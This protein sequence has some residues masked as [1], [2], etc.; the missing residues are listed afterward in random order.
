VP[1]R[2]AQPEGGCRVSCPG[3]QTRTARQN[4]LQKRV[5]GWRAVGTAILEGYR[6]KFSLE[7][8]VVVKVLDLQS[9]AVYGARAALLR[10]PLRVLRLF[11]ALGEVASRWKW[12]GGPRFDHY[13]EALRLFLLPAEGDLR[14]WVPPDLRALE[15]L[16]AT[17]FA[18]AAHDRLGP[19]GSPPPRA[20]DSRL[21]P[22][23]RGEVALALV[24]Q[25]RK[26]PTTLVDLARAALC[27]RK[28][29][30]PWSTPPPR[31]MAALAQT[32]P[33]RLALLVEEHREG[34]FPPEDLLRACCFLT[35]PPESLER[36]TRKGLFGQ[37]ESPFSR[38]ARRAFWRL[39]ARRKAASVREHAVIPENL[40]AK[41]PY[42]SIEEALDLE[43]LL[44][45]A[46]LSPRE[47]QVVLLR[48]DGLTL[49]EVAARLGVTV[50]TVSQLLSRVKRKI[51]SLMS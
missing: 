27:P 47:K 43:T 7:A 25:H 44:R 31:E 35:W 19:E 37:A 1:L 14:L 9:E 10:D 51:S 12:P 24:E 48:L 15:V 29:R 20:R 39:V 49:E 30:L 46:G 6:V 45:K 34:S 28:N 41:D 11:L 8:A 36:C 2:P 13:L 3:V 17:A 5:S 18:V 22:D 4:P 38:A 26:T 40:P 42:A 50:G 16:A 21:D 23:A 33:N 32:S